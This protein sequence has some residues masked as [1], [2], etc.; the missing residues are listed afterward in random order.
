MTEHARVPRRDK[1]LIPGIIAQVDS[2]HQLWLMEILND[3]A[4]NYVEIIYSNVQVWHGTTSIKVRN[5][6]ADLWLYRMS[7]HQVISA[8]VF[9]R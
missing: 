6:K 5:D 2:N 9:R 3:V 4:E 1:K 7:S 8:V